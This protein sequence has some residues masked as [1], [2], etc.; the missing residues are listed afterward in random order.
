[1][2]LL[3]FETTDGHKVAINPDHIVT[4]IEYGRSVELSL[5]AGNHQRLL[6]KLSLDEFVARIDSPIN[7]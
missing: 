5:V 6:I 7:T 1:M 3:T 4:A 2:R